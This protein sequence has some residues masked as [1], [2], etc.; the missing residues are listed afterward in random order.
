MRDY[1]DSEYVEI[2]R[3][4]APTDGRVYYLPHPGVVTLDSETTKLRLV[5][6]ASSK[7]TNEI[8][9]IETLLSGPKLQQDIISILLRFKPGAV[10]LT[11]PRMTDVVRL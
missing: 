10:A 9:L 3:Q 5:F 2:V 7:C 11:A 4:S 1:L 6:D 8:A